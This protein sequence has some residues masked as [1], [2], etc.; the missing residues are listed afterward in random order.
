MLIHVTSP[1]MHSK[2]IGDL[3]LELRRL[4]Y[5]P[6]PYDDVYGPATAA[7][8]RAFQH[9]HK[10]HVDGIFGPKTLV[11]LNA[12][13]VKLNAA[14][15]KPVEIIAPVGVRALSEG[16]THLGVKESPAGS[17]HNPFGKWI[18]ADG[19]PWCA[20]FVSY[21]FVKGAGV[22]LCH[23]WHGPGVLSKGCSYVPTVEKW[24]RATGQWGGRAKPQPGDIAIFNWDGGDP[25]HIGI[26]ERY[27]GDGRFY[28]IEGNTSL[29]NNSNGGEVM[30]RER[31]VAQTNGFGRIK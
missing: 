1:P 31:L 28:S 4:G 13:I 8:V 10:L 14:G 30:R 23:G 26:V 27:I 29:S 22:T 7:A 19:S 5:R 20:D 25:D 21:C 11:A 15:K 3:Q 17:N 6:G 24:L 2:Q 16:L 9:D 18:G 12:A